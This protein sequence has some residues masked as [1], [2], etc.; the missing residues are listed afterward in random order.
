MEGSAFKIFDMLV[1][2]QLTSKAIYIIAKL[3][4]ADYL[5]DGPKDIEVLAKE[6]DSS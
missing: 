1:I 5:K 6:T 4:I 2:G 3:N